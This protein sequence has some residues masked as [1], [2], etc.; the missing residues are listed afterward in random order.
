MN[1]EPTTIRVLTQR[2]KG[3]PHHETLLT[4]DWTGITEADLLML[5]ANALVRD[6]QMV[7]RGGP[8]PEEYTVMAKAHCHAPLPVNWKGVPQAWKEGTDKPGKK[9]KFTLEELLGQLSAE[10]LMALLK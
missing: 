3:K 4:I 5:A 2:E 1:L 8:I 7:L 10:E 9:E 6:A